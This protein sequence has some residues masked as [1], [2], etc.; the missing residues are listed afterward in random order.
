VLAKVR[1]VINT[2]L[3]SGYEEGMLYGII[4]WYVPLERS[5]DTYNKQPLSLA[6]LGNRKNNLTL[7]LNNVYGDRET[8]RW[9]KEAWAETGKKL[10]MGESCVCTSRRSMT[11][12]WMSL[13]R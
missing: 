1:G 6:G 2:N 11:F 7:H 13:A 5:P 9:F 3:P 10:N 12:R 8:E 4:G